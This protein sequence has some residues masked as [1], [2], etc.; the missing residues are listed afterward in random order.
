MKKNGGLDELIKSM[1]PVRLATIADLP[2]CAELLGILFGQER[3]FTPDPAVQGKGLEMILRNPGAGSVFVYEEDALVQG[4]VVLLFTIS[5]A[6]GKRVAIL[7]DMVVAPELR[8]RSVGTRLV[9]AA[10]AFAEKNGFGRVT[11]LTD[12]D[13]EAAHRFYLRGGFV[14]SDMIV[15]RR[16]LGS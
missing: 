9:E 13:N 10:V 16:L 4:M 14:K 15:F 2:R 11:L 1:D 6:L 7:E 5:T 8:G 3:E 12:H